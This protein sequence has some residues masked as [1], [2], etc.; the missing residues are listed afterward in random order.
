MTKMLIKIEQGIDTVC[1]KAVHDIRIRLEQVAIAGACPPAFHG[2]ALHHAVGIFAAD[3]SAMSDADRKDKAVY[4]ELN[5]RCVAA[6]I[7]HK[8]LE[9]LLE[10]SGPPS[11]GL[12]SGFS[13]C[14]W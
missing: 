11:C 5:R 4:E 9:L 13:I 12:C 3:A 6:L 7:D 14:Y 8:W 1:S 2:I 10:E